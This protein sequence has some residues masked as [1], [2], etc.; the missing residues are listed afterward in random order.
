MDLY[1]LPALLERWAVRRAA[2]GGVLQSRFFTYDAA[3]ED[4]RKRAQR[5]ADV[6]GNPSLW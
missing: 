3:A 6:D 5:R 4:A 2:R 1:L